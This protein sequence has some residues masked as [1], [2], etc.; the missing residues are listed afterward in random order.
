[1][2]GRHPWMG[3]ARAEGAGRK[4]DHRGRLGV[5]ERIRGIGRGQL[6]VIGSRAAGPSSRRTWKERRASLRAMVSDARVWLR[7]RAF[8]ARKSAWSGL[9]GRHAESAAS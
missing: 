8:R 7:P 5:T 9:E 2:V 4:G 1:M 3:A 6:V